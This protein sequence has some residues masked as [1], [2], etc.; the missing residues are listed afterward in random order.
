ML[1]PY[2]AEDAR[3]LLKV[4]L[5]GSRPT[6]APQKCNP[7]DVEKAIGLEPSM[8]LLAVGIWF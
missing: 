6:F 8:F 4:P 2:D 1:A 7:D 3:G 5:P